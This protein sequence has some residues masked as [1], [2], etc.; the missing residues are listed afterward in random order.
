MLLCL[1]TVLQSA[2]DHAHMHDMGDMVTTADPV[3][4]FNHHMAGWAVILLAL[5]TFLEQTRLARFAWIRYGWPLVLTVEAVF[6][7]IWSDNPQFWPFDLHRW[8]RHWG[9]WQ[10]KIF[11]T[12]ALV[13]ALI[14]FLRRRGT[15][16]GRD[17]P[18]I[19]NVLILGAGVF[20]FFHK[21]H[22]NAT[23]H[24]EHKWMAI[25]IL[26]I[27][28]VKTVTDIQNRANWLRMYV[29]PLCFLALGLQL[30]LYAE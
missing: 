4:L 14:E 17:W 1:L 25:E 8:A 27:G 21:G 6:L 5:F 16:V 26:A 29:L 9:A 28:A 19:L 20:L 24:V 12:T 10:H 18:H 22:H 13:L 11:A 2:P 30:A 23:I 15:L 3:S 7:L